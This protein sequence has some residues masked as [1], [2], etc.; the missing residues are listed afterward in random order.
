MLHEEVERLENAAYLYY[1]QGFDETFAQVKHFVGESMVNLSKVDWERKLEEMLV[2]RASINRL[3]QEVP[4]GTA[5]R[6]M[7]EE[8][9]EE[10]GETPIYPNL[11]WVVPFFFFM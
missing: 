3:V 1:K 5:V 4:V 11:S 8:E 9:E 2:K 7:L 10:E 6:V